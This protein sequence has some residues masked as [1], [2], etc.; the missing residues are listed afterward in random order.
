MIIRGSLVEWCNRPSRRQ[1]SGAVRLKGCFVVGRRNHGHRLHLP[2]ESCLVW[3][4]GNR[5]KLASRVACGQVLTDCTSLLHADDRHE[6]CDRCVA[7]DGR[8]FIVYRFF[9][10]SD[11]LLYVGYSAD[12]PTRL[13]SHRVGRKP[14][15]WF[16]RVT[17]WTLVSFT[18]SDA[19]LAYEEQ[20]IRSERPLHNVRHN[21][22]VL[23]A[24]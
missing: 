14:S 8:Q 19:A 4:D 16:Q 21:D 9:G 18:T 1:I 11:E 15:L 3:L 13:R 12:F 24:A 23:L 20:V 5:A 17:R 10:S 7:A 22:A 2:I 6:M